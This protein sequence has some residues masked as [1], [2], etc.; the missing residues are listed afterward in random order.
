M[1]KTY[2][3]L[4]HGILDPPEGHIRLPLARNPLNRQK[5]GVYP[6]GKVTVTSYRA[7]KFFPKNQNK[8]I[9][10]D[11]QG[12]TLVEVYPL[13]GRTHQIRVV[14]AFMRHP[15]V[16]DIKYLSAK[17][18]KEDLLWT[19]RHFLHAHKIS[20]FHPDTG[21]RVNFS[22]QLPHDLNEILTVMESQKN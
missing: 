6:G 2:I 3:A 5:W 8:P 18:A 1:E 21:G 10:S 9:Q 7:V 12:Y 11:Y 14:F 15:L 22:A 4:V 19:K 13:T 17:K 16:G 20:F